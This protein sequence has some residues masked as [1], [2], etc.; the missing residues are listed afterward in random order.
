MRWVRSRGCLREGGVQRLLAQ[1]TLMLETV[2][3]FSSL[4]TCISHELRMTFG[5]RRRKGFSANASLSSDS[6]LTPLLSCKARAMDSL[7]M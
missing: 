6:G 4:E 5:L 7:R 3:G 1:G 2:G